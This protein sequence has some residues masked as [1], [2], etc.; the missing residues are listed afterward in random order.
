MELNPKNF[1][2]LTDSSGVTGTA[3]GHHTQWGRGIT[4]H[5]LNNEAPKLCTSSV[6]HFYSHPLLASMMAPSVGIQYQ[7]CWSVLVDGKIITDGTKCGTSG[8]VTTLEKIRI[9]KIPQLDLI[10]ASV[11]S[12]LP[13]L[14]ADQ[15]KWRDIAE[16]FLSGGKVYDGP[17]L[18][19]PS[20]DFCYIFLSLMRDMVNH[21][22]DETINSIHI[23]PFML[24]YDMGI[25]VDLL[26]AFRVLGYT[27]EHC[28]VEALRRV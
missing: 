23:A 3:F 15:P 20:S 7:T 8:S 9:P 2:K 26:A 21:Q 25:D 4:N 11:L 12:T 17:D 24:T 5:P 22:A 1:C 10:K 28:G 6:V 14:A 19:W 18:Y 13:I 27:D 16:R